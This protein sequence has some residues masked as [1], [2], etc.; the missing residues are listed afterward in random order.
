MI[1]VLAVLALAGALVTL[2]TLVALHVLPTGLSPVRDP[3]SAYGISRFGGLYRAQT[4]GTALSAA[5]LA[6]AV[7]LAVPVATPAVIA[8]AA[9]A[10]AR[11]LIS[12]FPM[13]APDAPRSVTGRVHN[14]L[15]YLAFA[16][17]S[18]SGFMIGI[19]F[20]ADASRAA[21]APAAT[22]LGWVATAASAITIAA[23]VAAPLKPVFGL[24]ERVIY[25]GMLGM[26]GVGAVAIAVG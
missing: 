23:S 17:A 10:L 13:D 3:V 22:L 21:F 26:L 24:A 19:A 4:L 16:A 2:C 20:S 7:A 25:V 5:A 8:L 12:W 18:V 6:V 15:A 1:Q 14:L 11:G 9:L